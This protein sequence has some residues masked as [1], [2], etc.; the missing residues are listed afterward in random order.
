MIDKKIAPDTQNPSNS[1]G[2]KT[3]AAI[4]SILRRGYFTRLR[5]SSEKNI[6][7]ALNRNIT[8]KINTHMRQKESNAFIKIMTN[9]K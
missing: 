3:L 2:W 4:S 7:H 1:F 9:S 8:S 5:L 6:I